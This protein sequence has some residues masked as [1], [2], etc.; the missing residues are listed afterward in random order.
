MRVQAAR[1]E[2]QRKQLITA[3]V[4]VVVVVIAVAVGLVIANRPK[5]AAPA[6]GASASTALT[7][8]TT[9]PASTLDNAAAPTAV[10]KKLD[11]GTP[12]TADG[13][14]KVLYVGAEYCPFCAMERWALIGA[15]SRFGT[16]S[17]LKPTTSSSTD[18]FPDTPTWSF[19]GST[20]TSEH[21][22]FEAV[23][24]KDREGK[25]LQELTGDNLAIFQKHNP[26]GGI[27]WIT[28]GGTHATS[29]ATVKASL[30]EGATYDQLIAGVLD[31]SSEI[32]KSVDA[33]INAITAQTCALTKGQPANVCTSKAV[34]TAAPL[35][36]K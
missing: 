20:F 9:L 17:G 31:P 28:Y 19:V 13:K 21:V 3:V 7:K 29:G 1:K 35:L 10:P 33:Q 18:S 8:L 25:P 15:L 27:P 23:E 26:E 2:R 5:E 22:A 12:L 36:E 6:A 32:G 11:G 24:T 14:P 34:M 4:A 16:F 30:F